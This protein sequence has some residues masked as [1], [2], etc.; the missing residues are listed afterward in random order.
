MWPQRSAPWAANKV[1]FSPWLTL[2]T[3]EETGTWPRQAPGRGSD[4]GSSCSGPAHSC[5][6]SLHTCHQL[7]TTADATAALIA[8]PS[9]KCQP[10]VHAARTNTVPSSESRI[11]HW[12]STAHRTDERKQNKTGSQGRQSPPRE[13]TLKSR[14]QSVISIKK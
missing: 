4:H 2:R 9:P 5:L 11:H 3:Q 1:L 6:S 8:E 12:V 7:L 13:S 10:R 14:P